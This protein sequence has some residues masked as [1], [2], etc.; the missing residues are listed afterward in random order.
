M[1]TQWQ[2]ECINALSTSP[3]AWDLFKAKQKNRKM[4]DQFINRL[5][6]YKKV[7]TKKSN[8]HFKEKKLSFNALQN[9]LLEIDTDNTPSDEMQFYCPFRIKMSAKIKEKF[10]KL[11]EQD[12]LINTYAC[13]NNFCKILSSSDAESI[14]IGDNRSLT[15]SLIFRYEMDCDTEVELRY[16]YINLCRHCNH[17]KKTIKQFISDLKCLK[18]EGIIVFEKDDKT[19]VKKQTKFIYNSLNIGIEIEYDGIKTPNH[20][21][22]QLPNLGIVSFDSGFDGDCT[23]RLRENRIRLDGIKGIK[24]LWCL[25]EHMKK[26]CML[27]ANS[28]VHMHIDCK[29]DN[30]ANRKLTKWKDFAKLYNDE[31]QNALRKLLKNSKYSFLAEIFDLKSNNVIETIVNNV[32]FNYEFLTLEYRFCKVSLDYRDFILQMIIL[33][34]ITE[35]LKHSCSLN[36]NLLMLVA[37]AVRG[38]TQLKP[39]MTKKV[40]HRPSKISCQDKLDDRDSCNGVEIASEAFVASTTD[41]CQVETGYINDSTANII[42]IRRMYNT[43]CSTGY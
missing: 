32:R 28:S 10:Y 13:S 33:I 39:F 35:C 42:R 41:Y 7:K 19:K 31:N 22:K 1:A 36:K 14:R 8:K 38:N 26:D 5:F 18:K 43:L 2:L 6:P 9:A 11:V 23:S 3:T 20:I 25:L 21:V 12:K 17:S 34:H 24:G 16:E 15:H 40:D 30:S 27:A 4:L 37:L 29:Y